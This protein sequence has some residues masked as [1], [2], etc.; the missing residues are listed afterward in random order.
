[1]DLTIKSFYDSHFQIQF[2]NKWVLPIQILLTFY[3]TFWM[4]LLSYLIFLCPLH[5]LEWISPEIEKGESNSPYLFRYK[6][7]LKLW[8]RRNWNTIWKF[9]LVKFYTSYWILIFETVVK[10]SGYHLDIFWSNLRIT[11]IGFLIISNFLTHLV[12]KREVFAFWNRC[13]S[14][15]FIDFSIIDPW[16]EFFG[17]FQ[18]RVLRELDFMKNIVI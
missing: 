7:T 13:F 11:A 15:K 12:Y 9:L 6:K 4:Q 17:L 14:Y 18:L 1:M 2:P 3:N 10:F 5:R 8:L 16:D